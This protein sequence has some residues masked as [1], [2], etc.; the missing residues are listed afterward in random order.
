MRDSVHA[1]EELSRR[2][3]SG[4]PDSRNLL[5]TA[6]THRAETYQKERCPFSFA[7]PSRVDIA[8]LK[9]TCG[10]QRSHRPHIWVWLY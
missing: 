9:K 2:R 8:A 4:S 3:G 7:L 5:L 1:I 6:E 10:R